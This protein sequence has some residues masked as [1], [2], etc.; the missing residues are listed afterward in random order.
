MSMTVTSLKLNK[1][2]I[3]REKLRTA[4]QD[5]HKIV[6]TIAN[7]SIKKKMKTK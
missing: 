7:P 6:D 4:L 3:R 5:S 2:K 1:N